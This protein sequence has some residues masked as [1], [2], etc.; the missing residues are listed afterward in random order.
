MNGFV[1]T[2][3]TAVR[4]VG[5]GR[6]DSTAADVATVLVVEDEHLIAIDT[7]DVLLDLGYGVAGPAMTLEEGLR[8]AER[9]GFHAALLDVNLTE[10]N[11]L[12]I[13]N[14]L[15]ARGVPFAYLTGYGRS[16]FDQGFPKA[17][18]LTKPVISDDVGHVLREILRVA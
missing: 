13:A 8:L 5:V 4:G 6:D 11:S 3:G 2:G 9:G 14:M 1:G 16:I 7:E 12:P 18:V 17:P 10:G 15:R